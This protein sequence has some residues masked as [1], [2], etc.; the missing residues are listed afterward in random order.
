MKIK[1]FKSF[2]LL[3]E[4]YSLLLKLLAVEVALTRFRLLSELYSLLYVLLNIH[5]CI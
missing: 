4:L 3:S 2:R 5:K 1:E